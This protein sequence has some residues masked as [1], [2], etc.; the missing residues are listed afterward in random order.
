MGLKELL[1]TIWK[2][3][4]LPT[5]IMIVIITSITVGV[6]GEI[7][8]NENLDFA[9]GYCLSY[10]HNLGAGNYSRLTLREG[11]DFYCEGNTLGTYYQTGFISLEY[12]RENVKCE[13]I[14]CHII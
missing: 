2:Y 5:F 9:E 14:T 6:I 3:Y 8:L 11:G 10:G 4:K 7:K 12:A 1:K 13:E